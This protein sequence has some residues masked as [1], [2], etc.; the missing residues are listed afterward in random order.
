MV[1]F[2]VGLVRFGEEGGAEVGGGWCRVCFGFVK[3]VKGLLQ[4]GFSRGL[5]LV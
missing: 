1:G 4:G 3:H 2:S 5:G